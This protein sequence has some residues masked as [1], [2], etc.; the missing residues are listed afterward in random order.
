V[1]V[2][3]H[4]PPDCRAGAL[5]FCWSSDAVTYYSQDPSHDRRLLEL[6]A[7]DWIIM[8]AGIALSAVIALVL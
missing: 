7:G 3:A 6:E 5:P 8:A 4:R 1:P 2:S